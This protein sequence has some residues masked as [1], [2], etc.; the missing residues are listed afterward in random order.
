MTR[1]RLLDLFCGAG[2]AAMGYYRAGFDV[3]GVDIK[4]QPNYPFEF[5]WDDALEAV[6]DLACGFDAI[7][8]SPPCQ[9]YMRSGMVRK[10][11]APDLVGQTRIALETAGLPWVIENVP[12]APIRPDIVL[13]GSM[14]GLGVRRHRW[15]ETNWSGPLMTLSCDHSL[16]ITGVYGHPHGKGGAWRNGNKPMLPSDL[17][18]WCK[19]MGIDWMT[20]REI[21]QAIPPAYT[22]HIGEYLLQAV[23]THEAA[24]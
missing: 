9:H 24:V 14:F 18:T 13:C 3:V 21:S 15:F 8:A 22:E 19:A 1:P 16:P 5:I 2:G 20:A 6:T 7:H 12:G 4:K 23:E 10:D 11:L 17:P